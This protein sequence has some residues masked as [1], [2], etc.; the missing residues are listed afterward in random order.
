LKGNSEEKFEEFAHQ[1][2]S[3][4]MTLVEVSSRYAELYWAGMDG[5]WEYGHN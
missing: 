1:V 4:S 5:N 3:F 2:G